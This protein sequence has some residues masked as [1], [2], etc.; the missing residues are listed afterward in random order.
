MEVF[1]QQEVMNTHNWVETDVRQC[2]VQTRRNEERPLHRWL[3]FCRESDLTAERDWC[4]SRL[5]TALLSLSNGEW[6]DRCLGLVEWKDN[7]R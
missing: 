2:Q 5:W 1:I 7:E 3:L 6:K 4:T